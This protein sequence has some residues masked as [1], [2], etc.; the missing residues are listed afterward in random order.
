M[1]GREGPAAGN[2]HRQ[3]PLRVAL[4]HVASRRSSA[5]LQEK[6]RA[7]L[8]SLPEVQRRRFLL[9][10]LE[11][12]PVKLLARMEGCSDRAS[13]YSLAIARKNLRKALEE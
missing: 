9:H 5:P 8:W 7:A 1:A 2:P 4:S 12:V 3:H 13:K 6:L 11:G 10:H